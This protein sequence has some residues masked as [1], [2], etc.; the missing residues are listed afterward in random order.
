M[1]QERPTERRVRLQNL[2]WFGKSVYL[3]GAAL[4]LTAN[5]V[6]AT[7]KRVSK[8][9][10]ESKEEFNRGVN[11]NIED[12]RIVGEYRSSDSSADEESCRNR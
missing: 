1:S 10:A 3:G 11:P 6:D 2:N 7:A 9:A 5:L 4:R 12:A 8:I